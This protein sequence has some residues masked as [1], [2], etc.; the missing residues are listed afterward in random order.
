MPPYENNGELLKVHPEPSN[1]RVKDYDKDLNI[2]GQITI[3][4]L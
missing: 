3:I 1:L 2:I 4:H